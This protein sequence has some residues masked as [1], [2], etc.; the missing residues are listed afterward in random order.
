VPALARPAIASTEHRHAILECP[1]RGEAT[2][3][4]VAIEGRESAEDMV[5]SLKLMDTSFP[6]EMRRSWKILFAIGHF[7]E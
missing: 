2:D 7:T 4:G 5:G 1:E 3:F 6:K